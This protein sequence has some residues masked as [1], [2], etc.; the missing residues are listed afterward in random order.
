[1]RIEIPKAT[2]DLL[3]PFNND[4]YR[5]IHNKIDRALME[6]NAIEIDKEILGDGL[7][8]DSVKNGVHD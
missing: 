5:D 3:A 7:R 2:A 4:V 8:P 6:H 1:M